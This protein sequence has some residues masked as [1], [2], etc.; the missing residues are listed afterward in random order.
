MCTVLSFLC[1]GK[2]LLYS[3]LHNYAYWDGCTVLMDNQYCILITVYAKTD[4]LIYLISSTLFDDWSSPELTIFLHIHCVLYF[5]CQILGKNC[6][7]KV[8]KWMTY[9][10]EFWMVIVNSITLQE[11]IHLCM[12]T[13]HIRHGGAWYCTVLCIVLKLLWLP[14]WRQAIQQLFLYSI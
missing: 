4:S 13:C 7:E 14:F 6:L 5:S 10:Y 11:P 8:C 12:H 2:A 3:C 1:S 9:T